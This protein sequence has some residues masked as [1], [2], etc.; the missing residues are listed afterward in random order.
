MFDLGK[1]ERA[2]LDQAQCPHLR[3][4]SMCHPG[5]L[6]SA[7]EMRM[8]MKKI[9]DWAKA[10]LPLV[11]SGMVLHYLFLW[12]ERRHAV[13]LHKEVYHKPKY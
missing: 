10:L 7:A 5:I 11:G 3:R 6:S 4:K 2:N 13:A 9:S 1:N 8:M 12:H